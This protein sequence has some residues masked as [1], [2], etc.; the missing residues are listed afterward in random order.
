MWGSKGNLTANTF[1]EKTFCSRWM[2]IFFHFYLIGCGNNFTWRDYFQTLNPFIL[3]PLIFNCEYVND[4]IWYKL[5]N[6]TLK[7]HYY[8]YKFSGSH[9]PEKKTWA[10]LFPFHTYV[11]LV[12]GCE[13]FDWLTV[14]GNFGIFTAKGEVSGFPIINYP[15]VHTEKPESQPSAFCS[16]H[17][18][19]ARQKNI[20][21]NLRA[22]IHDYCQVPKNPDDKIRQKMYT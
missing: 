15:T 11:F 5:K 22:F 10:V 14:S 17:S 19:L 12:K 2:Y 18:E 6:E 4:I 16:K 9:V 1:V 20:P 8:Q 21:T 7:V 13:N 3:Q